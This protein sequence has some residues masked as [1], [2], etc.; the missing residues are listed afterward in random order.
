MPLEITYNNNNNK[1]NE[2]IYIALKNA[3]KLRGALVFAAPCLLAL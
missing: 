3:S 1:N 2:T